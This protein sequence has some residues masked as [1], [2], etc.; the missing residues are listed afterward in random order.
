MC[1]LPPLLPNNYSPKASITITDDLTRQ[2][3]SHAWFNHDALSIPPTIQYQHSLA[4][5]NLAHS[6]E[7]QQ[8]AKPPTGIQVISPPWPQL[9][10]ALSLLQKGE[11]GSEMEA[12]E[13]KVAISFENVPWAFDG[14]CKGKNT[15]LYKSYG[16]A[17]P[18]QVP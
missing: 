15:L 2:D 11:D 4:A 6:S 8:P 12:A 17:N 1:L 14:H 3:L 9:Q 5:N 16:W 7:F 13:K 10:H 18:R